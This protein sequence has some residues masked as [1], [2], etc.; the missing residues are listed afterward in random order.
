MVFNYPETF[1]KYFSDLVNII[2]LLIVSN[3]SH[4]IINADFSI[5]HF[6]RYLMRD[7]NINL[8]LEKRSL[9]RVIGDIFNI[10]KNTKYSN[11]FP[12]QMQSGENKRTNAERVTIIGSRI[13]LYIINHLYGG[14]Y[15]DEKKKIAM[16]PECKKEGLSTNTSFLRIKSKEFHH[17]DI[18][19]EGYSTPQLY[20]LFANNK[21]LH[22]NDRGNPY[23]LPNIIK[24]MESESVI[25]RCAVHHHL[26][27]SSYFN[28]FKKFINW[29]NIPEEFPQDI[30]DLPSEFI[31]ILAMICVDNFYKTKSKNSRQKSK[32]KQKEIIYNIKK[33]YIIDR[34]YA[35]VCP[36]CGDFNTNEHL[37]AFDFNHLNELKKM[38]FWEREKIEEER[39]ARVKNLYSLP[40]SE[41][42]EKLEDQKG[43]Y[44]CR[45]CHRVIHDDIEFVNE[46]FGDKNIVRMV[47]DD[48]KSIIEKYRQNL[49]YNKESI[50]NPLRT[51]IEI[52]RSL[53]DY[54]FALFEISE[55]K[56]VVTTDN[57]I[58]KMSLSRSAVNNFFDIRKEFLKKYGKIIIG[59]GPS[60]PT[61]YYVNDKGKKLMRLMIYFRD[62]YNK[63]IPDL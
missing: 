11:L 38:T 30:F 39:E 32:L 7:K 52:R 59:K 49:I 47:T 21:N 60:N 57:L 15:F 12:P 43:G 62:F 18:K 53:I 36:T 46:I 8:F 1:I 4:K 22:Q 33:R 26:I 63:L 35:G 16:C 50:K 37:T 14:E 54:L 48:C 42:V 51:D 58:N 2:K 17:E 28:D 61:K 29:E 6:V 5:K 34:I 13:K 20:N 19:I 41:L 56:S 9:Q 10:L 31:H 45:N 40:C 24:K 23:F 55:E 3:K 27:H 25:L 44:I